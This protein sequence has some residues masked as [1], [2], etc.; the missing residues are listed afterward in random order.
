LAG[1]TVEASGIGKML[2]ATRE[3]KIGALKVAIYRRLSDGPAVTRDELARLL[4]AAGTLV[5]MEALDGTF[6]EAAPD[7]RRLELAEPRAL[8]PKADV[9][10]AIAE[11]RSV[12][13]QLAA[14]LSITEPQ[15]RM[16]VKYIANIIRLAEDFGGASLLYDAAEA[17]RC[18]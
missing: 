2:D 10:D 5:M 9:V 18:R 14:V 13:R 6:D 15:A 3:E 1:A 8:G 7:N 12:T 4:E 16:L 11:M 17:K